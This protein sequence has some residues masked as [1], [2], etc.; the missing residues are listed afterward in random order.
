MEEGIT[1]V[2]SAG[3]NNKDTSSIS[4][5][6]LED[7]GVIVVGAAA[8]SGGDYVKASYSNYGASVDVY[9]FGTNILSCSGTGGYVTNSGTS[10]SAPHISA[11]SAMLHLIHPGMLPEE[12]EYR[13]KTGAAGLSEIKVPDLSEMVPASE[14]FYLEEL[15][16]NEGESLHIPATAL[17]AAACENITYVS[18][19][20]SV[21]VAADGMITA[22]SEGDAV[23]TAAC[24]GF[25]PVQFNVVVRKNSEFGTLQLPAGLVK[26]ED[27]AF[28]GL[29]QIQEL[30]IPEGVLEI[31]ES[32]LEA[33]DDLRLVRIPDSV[34]TIGDNT[35]SGAVLLCGADSPAM[36]F[37]E[38]NALQYIG[39]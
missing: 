7:E 26:I 3:N 2:C 22:C 30:S 35:F 24:T 27:E 29:D 18:S 13:I 8:G 25:S 12:T 5:A 28:S 33:C 23:I 15:V 38:E 17:P 4:P 1:V 32:V 20:S 14:G 11:L 6:H 37:A 21:A 31:G 16:L 9:A 10:V 39:E 19:D 36:A 34:E